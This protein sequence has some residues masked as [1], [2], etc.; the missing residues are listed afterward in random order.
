MNSP[1]LPLLAVLL[2]CSTSSLL[3]AQTIHL[4][5]RGGVV[6]ADRILMGNEGVRVIDDTSSEPA[7]DPGAEPIDS[8]AD[9][10]V[11]SG[12][13]AEDSSPNP[14]EP[15]GSSTGRLI[16]WDQVRLIDGI[17]DPVLAADWARWQPVADDLWRA[18]SRLQ[19]GDRARSEPL[20]ERHFDRIIADP[21]GSELALIVA[22][23]LLR[24]RLRSGA[25]EALLP[26]ALET[27]RLRRAGFSTDRYQDL[28]AVLDEEFW[29]V[30]RLAPIPTR[31]D[32]DGSSMRRLLERWIDDPDPVVAGIARAYAM[33]HDAPDSFIENDLLQ[34]A[35]EPGAS[36][37]VSAVLTGS[38]DPDRRAIARE[39]LDSL[40]AAG[41]SLETWREWFIG[42]SELR[43]E[44]GS[45][46]S[47]LIK[48]LSI[49]AVHLHRDPALAIRAI[50]ISAD[51]LEH[52]DRAD[53][54]EVL[55]RELDRLD[56]EVA[57]ALMP[58][59]LATDIPSSGVVPEEETR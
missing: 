51:A 38:S 36:L 6:Q 8:S 31:T 57:P 14:A 33:M 9:S 46:D 45:L 17:E 47:A 19:R 7:L 34:S 39:R 4:R 29:L 30:P 23:G 59:D 42:V 50:S 58:E 11:D 21:A 56:F 25:I 54:A 24:S 41:G 16:P 32:L 12:V 18:R 49:P 28:P 27:V 35:T 13:P 3:Q 2:A 43:E 40:L 20:F 48:L 22:E 15:L 1:R 10:P 55:R 53:E 26:A 5:D 44:S 52:A 37:L